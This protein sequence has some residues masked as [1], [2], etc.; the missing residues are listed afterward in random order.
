MDNNRNVTSQMDEDDKD[1]NNRLEDMIRHIGE[2]SYMKA[3]IYDILCNN[4][5]ASLYKGCTSFTRLSVLLKLFNLKAKGGWSDKSFIE[6]LDLL[7]QMLPEDNNLRNHCYDSKK[8]LC[9]MG[10]DYVKIQACHNDC[11]L[12]RKKCGNLDQCPEYGDP[13]YKLK[14]NNSDDNDNVSKKHPPTKLLWYLSI[15][16]RLK[17]LFVNAN[18]SKNIIC[19]VGER[20][21][22]ENIRHVADSLQLKKIDSLFSDFGLEPKNLML[23]IST[24]GMNPLRNMSI[25]HPS[26]HV[27]LMIYNLSPW[28][29]MK[30]KYMMLSMMISGPRQPGNDINVYL[31]TL[32]EDL[33]NL[34]DRSVDVDD[35]YFGEKFKMR[36]ILFY[37]FNE[38][39]AYDN[40]VGYSLKGHK[41]FPI[42]E[43][44]THFH[45]LEFGKKI[46]YLGHPKFLKP[47]HPCRRL[48]KTFNEEQEFKISPKPLTS[49]E[50][51]QR[52]ENPTIWLSVASFN[53]ICN[54][55]LDFKKLDELEDEVAII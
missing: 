50:V 10:L 35:S 52:Q 46:V 21:Y 39:P 9:Q 7:K 40:L 23:G 37:T 25:N 54:K 27:L 43:S 12:C 8:I 4:K 24:Y 26:W 17:K 42:C 36:A 51:Y 29:C 34:W 15:I 38:F 44:N 5:Y 28:L 31:S 45:G 22:D 30:R 2:S 14:N 33:K 41:V 20:K 48:L 19:H 11:I 13:C 53:A 1:M 18:D 6:L 32:I 49:G 16:L 3:H 47:N 55:V